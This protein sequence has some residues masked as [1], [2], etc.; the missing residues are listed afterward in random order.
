MLHNS[1][2]T[3]RLARSIAL[4]CSC[5]ATLP[6]SAQNTTSPSVAPAF[7]RGLAARP[8]YFPIAVWLQDPR[9]AAR[10]KEVG[11]NLYVGLW[12]GPTEE[13]LA[14]LEKAGM[15][16][17][18]SPTEWALRQKDR[19]IIVAWMH[20]DEPDNAQSLGEGRGY[21]PPVPTAKV[22]ED[23]Q[24]IR[25]LDPGRPVFLNLG[26][27][28]A[29]DNWYGRGVRTRH[30]EDYPE[31]AQA[32]DILSFDIY[33]VT[34]DKPE[35][36]GNLWYVGHGVERLRGW[37]GGRKPVWAC[38]ECTHI[39]NPKLRPT[40]AQVRSIVWMALIHGAGGLLYFAHEF[41]PAFVEAGLLAHADIREGVKQVNAQVA[42]LAPV[43]N[44]PTLEGAVDVSSSDAAVPIRTLCKRHDGKLY[45]FAIATRA[46]K[47]TARFR[48]PGLKGETPVTVL[49]EKRTVQARD[50]AWQDAFEPYAVH[51][52][53]IAGAGAARPRN[54]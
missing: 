47:T 16:V 7:E 26:Q 21:G 24:R 3:K 5:A 34:H 36:A 40:P 51:L 10:Y 29:W 37:S 43:L 33:P 54:R 14:T 17:I 35:V 9:N 8:D 52:Y 46:G 41:Q 25:R 30:P 6:A 44:S 38:I 19:K 50:G 18:C 20:E 2:A 4:V 1:W 32:A 48:V 53:E 15:P 22:I 11:I 28:V 39:G 31:Y 23:Y 13:Q 45:V 27:G 12:K 42:E 49:G